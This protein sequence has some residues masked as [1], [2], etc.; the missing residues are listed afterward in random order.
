MSDLRL[1]VRVHAGDGAE[2]GM[3][4]ASDFGGNQADYFK[5]DFAKPTASSADHKFLFVTDL[6]AFA[7]L[8][9][10][11]YRKLMPGVRVVHLGTK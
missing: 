5:K 6:Q 2:A 1:P 3:N 10:E 7:F 4:K 11:K 9:K 8:Q